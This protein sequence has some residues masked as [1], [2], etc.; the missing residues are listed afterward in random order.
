[1]RPD[2]RLPALLILAWL[3]QAALVPLIS[4][5][6]VQP[7]LILVVIAVQAIAGGPTTGALAGFFGG[8]LQ[9]LLAPGSVGIGTLVKTVIGYSLGR[10]D[11]ILLGETPVLPA[12]MIGVMSLISQSAYLGLLLLAGE[13]VAFVSY[14][15]GVILPSALY[16]AIIGLLLYPLLE[17]WSRPGRGEQAIEIS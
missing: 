4:I 15:P 2:L 7:D 3:A 1:M 12:I 9:D 6:T 8:L 11:R 13:R 16:T 10:I 17:R 14:L 5:G